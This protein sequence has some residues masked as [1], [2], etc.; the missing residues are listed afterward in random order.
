MAS[1][2]FLEKDWCL[3]QH[4]TTIESASTWQKHV[5]CVQFKTLFFNTFLRSF[6]VV[7]MFFIIAARMDTTTCI[8]RTNDHRRCPV[9]TMFSLTYHVLLQS[10]DDVIDT[11]QLPI[12][13]DSWTW[14]IVLC[15]W[16]YL[17]HVENTN[18]LWVE[19]SH[20]PCRCSGQGFQYDRKTFKI[21]TALVGPSWC[22][23]IRT[24]LI[25]WK[26][27]TFS[28][29]FFTKKRYLPQTLCQI[30]RLSTDVPTLPTSSVGC[31]AVAPRYKEN[32]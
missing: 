9:F 21:A 27:V 2:R 7:F 8:L 22:V 16:V 10:I 28:S 30:D 13:L 11:C 5:K 1:A 32:Y 12:E 23:E 18:I 20:L 25:I 3:T 14:V 31:G 15:A 29:T 4:N 24:L 6:C 19:N 17:L 26:S